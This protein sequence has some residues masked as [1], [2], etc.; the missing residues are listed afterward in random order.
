MT[1][2]LTQILDLGPLLSQKKSGKLD[3]N[4]RNEALFKPQPEKLSKL[5]KLKFVEITPTSTYEN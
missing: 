3:C 4:W 5:F 1:K 2:Y